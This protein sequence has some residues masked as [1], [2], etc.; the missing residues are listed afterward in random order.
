MHTNPLLELRALGQS[1]WLDDLHRGMLDDGT[2][3]SL[4]EQDGL[5]GLTSNPAILAAAIMQR[6]EY[7]EQVRVLLRAGVDAVSAYEALAIEDVGRAA[8]HFRALY[9]A[10]EGRDGFVSLEVSPHLAHDADGTVRDAQRLWRA[11]ERP[12]VMIKIPGTRAGLA[13]IRRTI[14]AGIN[15]NVTL[16]FSPERYREA[17]LAYVAGLRERRDRGEPVERVASVAS[18]FLSR[19]D[20][21]VDRRLETLARAGQAAA[22]ALRGKS[23][24]AAASR[25]YEIFGELTGTAEWEGLAGQGARPQRLLWAST[26]TKDPAYSPI[27]YVEEVVAYGTINTMPMPTLLAYREQ[28]H[29]ELR[30]ERACAE[31][32]DWREGFEHLGIDLEEVAEQLEEEGIRKFVEPFDALQAWLRR[33]R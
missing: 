14:A 10:S 6:A 25:A 13:A 19:I 3:A 5:A 26:S 23:A 18:F 17:A 29:P 27:K 33:A 31:A 8:D 2:L 32:S 20:T 28:G 15:V 4:I 16:L 1:V 22:R 11:L 24:V 12:N 9:E 30:L 7:R 21:L